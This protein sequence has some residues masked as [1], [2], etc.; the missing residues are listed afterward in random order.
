MQVTNHASQESNLALKPR[1]HVTRSL[2]TGVS[3]APQKGLMSSKKKIE[4]KNSVFIF[5]YRKLGT[6]RKNDNNSYMIFLQEN[7]T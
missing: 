2:K 1:A 5:H 4:K 7:I 6:K 3:V